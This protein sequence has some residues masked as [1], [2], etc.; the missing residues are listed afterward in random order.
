MYLNVGMVTWIETWCFMPL[1]S[2]WCIGHLDINFKHQKFTFQWMVLTQPPSLLLF[3]T[4]PHMIHNYAADYFNPFSHTTIL[5]QTTLNLFCQNIENLHNW[6]DNLW[7]KVE[8][9]VVKWEIARFVQFLLL[10]LFSKSLL[11]RRRPKAFIW[12]E[13]LRISRQNYEIYS[14]NEI[15]YWHKVLKSL[16]QI[17]QNKVFSSCLLPMCQKE[18]A[19]CGKGLTLSHIQTH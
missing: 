5:Q 19:L 16:L 10:S 1:Y 8:N 4:F 11:L 13:G 6:M 2:F 14:V 15:S 12:G 17:W 3:N 18:S 7:L 9:I